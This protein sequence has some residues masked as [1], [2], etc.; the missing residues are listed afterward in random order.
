MPFKF[1]ITHSW[2]DMDFAKKLC[3]DLSR[4]GLDGF[5]DA[6]S[7]RPGDSIPSRIERGLKECDVYIPVFSPDAV[8]SD[9]CDWEIDMAITMNRTRKGRPRIIPVI[10]K[11]CDV[12]DRLMHLLY[13]DFV[14]R[15]DD[16]LHE[17]LTK[18]FN[19][20]VGRP[21]PPPPAKSTAVSLGLPWKNWMLLFG[22]VAVLAII[23]LIVARVVLLAI[24]TTLTP[25]TAVPTLRIGET[26]TAN[27]NPG[28][29]AILPTCVTES[30]DRDGWKTVNISFELENRSGLDSSP[31]IPTS[32]AR[33]STDSNGVYPARTMEVHGSDS[34]PTGVYSTTVISFQDTILP[35]ERVRLK[36][37]GQYLFYIFQ[38]RIPQDARI[39]TLSIA[40]F[41][42]TVDIEKLGICL[43]KVSV[44]NISRHPDAQKGGDRII[45]T[46]KATAS[47]GSIAELDLRMRVFSEYNTIG[48][49]LV[50]PPDCIT[51]VSLGTTRTRSFKVCGLVPPG[52]KDV[53]VIFLSDPTQVYSAPDPP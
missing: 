25:P 11:P 38:A 6:H 49:Q 35:G 3:D 36:F 50:D 21:A 53:S 47:P 45:L 37:D 20:P 48:T 1:F 30:P 41:D 12:P 23:V 52:A 14:G 8:K 24:P 10:A 27:A 32:E 15:Y 29:W 17:L 33:I 46:L 28:R 5:L 40:G 13:V 7:I 43:T 9:W 18:G 19:L 39:K 2:K 26:M 42:G 51:S 34:E 16:A 31:S 4:N 44:E 22:A